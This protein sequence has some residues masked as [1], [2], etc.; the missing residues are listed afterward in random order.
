[1]IDKL[2]ELIFK[3]KTARQTMAKNF[4]WLAIGQFGSRFIRAAITIYAAR[5]LG[6]SEYGIFAYALGAASFF[7]IFS[8][9]GVSS[10]LAREVARKPGEGKKYFATIFAIK[11]AL[12]AFTV[13]LLVVVAPL[14]VKIEK[15]ASLMPLVALL[16]IFDGLREF[17]FS[18]FR[19]REKMELEAIIALAVNIAVTFF[20]FI[21][22]YFS[23]TSLTLLKVYIAGSFVGFLITVHLLREEYRGVIKYFSKELINPIV[24]AAWPMAAGG[25]VGAFMFNVDILMLGW[26]RTSAEIGFYS[27]GQ[28]I[29][30]MFYIIGGLLAGA[31][32]PAFFRIIYENNKERIRAMITKSM[33]IVL[34]AATPLAAG[35][36]ILGGQIIKLVFGNNYINAIPVFRILI[37]SLL[38]I[39]PFS[40][41]NNIIFA[42]NKQAKM[43]GYAIVVSLT[44]VIFNAVLIPVYGIIGAAIVTVFANFLNV[45]FMWRLVKKLNNFTILPDLKK[46]IMAVIGM[47][48]MAILLKYAGVMVIANVIISG[49]F[50][51]FLLYLLKEKNFQELLSL[52]NIKSKI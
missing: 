21:A 20:G 33:V 42:Y 23:P 27:V 25:I 46:I 7:M 18:F 10:I 6:A 48:L 37:S 52:V 5:I 8:D 9:I 24:K 26:W 3:N 50:Y 30:G 13:T 15:A 51:L 11:T 44:N 34:L 40:I 45:V 2:K 28:K 39:Y 16:V 32:G 47:A 49:V 17:A 41:L 19:G 1:M 4:L 31:M 36:I 35:G 43:L 29:V 14:F 12:L 22:L 38:I